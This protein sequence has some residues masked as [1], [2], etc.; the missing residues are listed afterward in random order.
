[1]QKSE[2]AN[3]YA[4]TSFPD[5][6]QF[7]VVFHLTFHSQWHAFRVRC[8]R[9]CS[10]K[11]ACLETILVLPLTR[12]SLLQLQKQVATTVLQSCA[13]NFVI[14]RPF[15][16]ESLQQ[17]QLCKNHNI[18]TATRYQVARS[19]MVLDGHCAMQKSEAAKL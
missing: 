19:K 11:F 6:I 7:C 3:L 1:M 16:H 13:C 17:R 12:V 2:A 14:F 8:Q 10:G 9:P 18:R 4:V 15:E 5:A